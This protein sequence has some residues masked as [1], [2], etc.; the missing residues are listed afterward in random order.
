MVREV[1]VSPDGDAVA[2]RSD[3]DENAWNA[4]GFIHAKT[5]GG[6][7]SSADVATWE[8]RPA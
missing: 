7:L 1:R 5:G 4:W 8:T 6:W 3:A 2:I